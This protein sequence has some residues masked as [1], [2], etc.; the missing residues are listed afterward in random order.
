[1]R[2]I[3]EV[4]ISNH[5]LITT[6]D[7]MSWTGFQKKIFTLFYYILQ[8]VFQNCYN[9]SPETAFCLLLSWRLSAPNWYKE[10]MFYFERSR[11]WQSSIFN[12]VVEHLVNHYSEKLNWDKQSV[13]NRQ[14]VCCSI[15]SLPEALLN[16]EVITTTSSQWISS[17]QLNH[18]TAH[19]CMRAW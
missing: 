13:T 1:M 4:S 19:C 12:D 7:N 6:V 18:T 17:Q 15:T 9:T 16:L 5:E 14:T 10:N 11:S 2:W 3:P 8:I